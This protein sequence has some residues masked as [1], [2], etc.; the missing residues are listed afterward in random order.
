M[1]FIEVEDAIV[2]AMAR[3]GLQFKDAS[4]H[5]KKGAEFE[6]AWTKMLGSKHRDQLLASYKE[7]FP[8]AVLPTDFTAPVRDDVAAL[9]QEFA[10]YREAVKKADEERR[11]KRSEET[12][13]RSVAEG[14]KWLRSEMKLDDE[15]E[16][17]VEQIMLDEGIH[18]YKAAYAYWKAQQPPEPTPL[19]SAYGGA[20]S[21]DWF[22][23]EESRPDTKLLL[24]DPRA[25]QRSETGKVLQEI[26]E[27]KF[28]A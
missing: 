15:G 17:G 4:G 9:R 11:T 23:T 12:A 28:A 10:D 19:P 24:S 18:N 1:P 3:E 21:L 2:A 26:R 27:G 20:R 7:V 14:R 5:I 8:D 22:K 25:F 13:N 16:R 6:A